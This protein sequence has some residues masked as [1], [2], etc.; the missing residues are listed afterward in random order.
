MVRLDINKLKNELNYE[1]FNKKFLESKSVMNTDIY[2]IENIIILC[3][4]NS[5]L[6]MLSYKYLMNKDNKIIN[7]LIVLSFAVGTLELINFN[8]NISNYIYLII[9]LFNIFIG[10][11]FNK[12][13]DMKLNILGQKHYEFYNSFEKIKLNVHTNNSI[14][15]SD[16]FLYK[17]IHA[18]IKYINTQIELLFITRPNIPSYILSEY[19]INKPDISLINNSKVIFNT[20]K[21]KIF[22]IKKLFN[23]YEIEPI[24]E[25]DKREY[26]DF[27]DNIR[28]K[29]I[30]K[31]DS[32]KDSIIH[33]L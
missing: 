18:Y 29:N 32:K 2:I 6:H 28:K 21:S 22:D 7:L 3:D 20:K 9:G 31:L 13:K 33:F 10:I 19:Q 11:V 14:K 26:K 30:E 24:N 5:K 27:I 16:A 23:L 8:V 12:H 15:N 17:D 4:Y 1:N 25:D